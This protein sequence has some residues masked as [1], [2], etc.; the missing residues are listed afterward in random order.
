MAPRSQAVSQDVETGW[1]ETSPRADRSPCDEGCG[2][3]VVQ[4][5]I[6][7]FA[8]RQ[9]DEEGIYLH[10]RATVTQTGSKARADARGDGGT[11]IAGGRAL[12]HTCDSKLRACC[13][14]WAQPW[15]PAV[16]DIPSI[17]PDKRRG[18]VVVVVVVVWMRIRD[19]VKCSLVV[20]GAREYGHS[21]LRGRGRS[22][23]Y[24]EG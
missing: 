19:D 24:G 2:L 1:R 3:S 14:S 4:F 16:A 10:I 23:M 22:R 8:T 20:I 5:T 12:W 9:H 7:L 18:V 17:G 13:R 15:F 21:E 6:R 11:G